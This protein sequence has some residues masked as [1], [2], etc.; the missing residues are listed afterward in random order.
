M[1]ACAMRS[2]NR[3][4]H[5]IKSF[6]LLTSMGPDESTRTPSPSALPTLRPRPQFP[7][8]LPLRLLNPH[9]VDASLPPP[10]QPVLIELPKLVPKASPPLPAGI[11]ALIHKPHRHPVLPEPP[12]LLAQPI[13]ELPRSHLRVSNSTIAARPTTHSVPVPPPRVHRVRQRHLL[14]IPRIPGILRLAHF[15]RSPSPSRTAATA[16][17]ARS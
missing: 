2:R 1:R 6:V 9:I 4:T 17:S 13:L 8:K 15:L 5:S 14:R 11:V 16:A 3:P 12:K 7:P 10:H